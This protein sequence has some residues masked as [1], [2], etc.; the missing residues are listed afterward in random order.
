[1]RISLGV[2]I[3]LSNKAHL[4]NS[5]L[6][7]SFGCGSAS[8]LYYSQTH[9]AFYG[10]LALAVYLMS[11]F[12][13]IMSKV[14]RCPQGPVLGFGFLSCVVLLLGSVW[15]VAYNFVPGGEFTRERTH[16]VIAVAMVMIGT[17]SW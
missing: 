5:L 16:I 1:M 3:F 4:T 7:W 15:T 2:G 12:P 8:V 6:W 13:C 9:T 10:G 11:I 17:L 14:Y